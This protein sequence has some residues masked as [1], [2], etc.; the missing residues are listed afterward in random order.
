MTQITRKRTRTRTGS[1]V[2]DGTTSQ[3]ITG[4]GFKPKW[5]RIY[6][7]RTVDGA[8]MPSF[9][10]TTEIMADHANGGCI[11]HFKDGGHTF[12][13]NKIISLDDDGFTVDDNGADD[14]PNKDGL[15]YRYI[16]IR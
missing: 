6:A 8:T 1:Y 16:A 13:T 14:A 12:E 10:T 9:E 4:I 3:A 7:K 11:A 2:G 5:L 15:D